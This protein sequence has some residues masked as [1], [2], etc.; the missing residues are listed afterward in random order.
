MRHVAPR[1]LRALLAWLLVI[2]LTAIAICVVVVSSRLL[3]QAP[4]IRSVQPD[5]ETPKMKDG[6]PGP[7]RR[8]RQVHPDYAKTN[9]YHALY[10]PTNWKADK[11]KRLPVIVGFGGDRGVI[12]VDMHVGQ[13]TLTRFGALHPFER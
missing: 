10:L 5:L 12:Q 9:V 6:E 7:G 1:L 2:G 3:A 8:V 4:D 11:K 13:H